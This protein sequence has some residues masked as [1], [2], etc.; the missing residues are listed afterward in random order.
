MRPDKNAKERMTS[1]IKGYRK[2]KVLVLLASKVL[3]RRTSR[4][5][6]DAHFLETF[7]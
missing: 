3:A 2:Q 7:E 5:P 1:G 6:M 4:R